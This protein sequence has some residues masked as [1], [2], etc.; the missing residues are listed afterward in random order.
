MKYLLDTNVFLWALNDDK[1]LKKPIRKILEDPLNEIFASVIC[2]WEISIKHKIGKLPLKTGLSECFEKSQF[3]VLTIN[4]N[5]ILQ[6]DK[7]PLYHK[8]PFDRILIAQA[9]A[10]DLILI[11]SDPKI[12]KYKISIIKA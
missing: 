5:H 10:E 8:D 2:G 12:W 7:L 3:S 6:L 9:K 1:R 4:L 11:S